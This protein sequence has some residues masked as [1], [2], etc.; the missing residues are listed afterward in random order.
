MIKLEFTNNSIII[1]RILLIFEIILRKTHILNCT[2]VMII[3]FK[4]IFSK[5]FLRFRKYCGQ[6][7]FLGTKMLSLQFRVELLRV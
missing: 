3:R 4:G 5:I 6:L 2:I 1:S 7:N